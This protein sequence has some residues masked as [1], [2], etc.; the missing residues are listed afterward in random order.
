M[1][2]HLIVTGLFLFGLAAAAPSHA[3]PPSFNGTRKPFTLVKP[4]RPAPVTPLYT[5]EG[6]VTNV[7]RHG[8]KVILL[9][10]WATW[11]AACLHELPALDRLQ[12]SYQKSDLVV[13]TVSVD[14]SVPQPARTYLERLGIRNLP[15][16]MDPA[17][18]T[19]KAF[20]VYDGLPW[21]FIIDRKGLLRGYLMG[22]ADWRSD[23]AK[24]L[25]AY[26]IAEK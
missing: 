1:V 21:S 4:L 24:Q 20:E 18:R 10:I 14:D 6:G 17:G 13:L 23:A 5:A 25:L 7:T 9:N 19:L 3:E 11:C 15:A 2:R 22:P 12:A 26:Y 8:G 16:L